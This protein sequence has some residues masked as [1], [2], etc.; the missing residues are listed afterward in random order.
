MIVKTQPMGGAEP[1][2]CIQNVA[3]RI[4]ALGGSAVFG[5][6][7][8]DCGFYV[9]KMAHVVWR[10]PEGELFDVTPY[11]T[12]VGEIDADG[13]YPV[14][15]EFKDIEFEPDSEMSFTGHEDTPTPIY[16]AKSDNWNLKKAL[17][18]HRT[19]DKKLWKQ[20]LGGAQYHARKANEFLKRSGIRGGWDVPVS[21][22]NV[23][24]LKMGL[25]KGGAA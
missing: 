19:V 7:V 24:Y 4:K 22:G 8:Q 5:W 20:D 3:K 25:A 16:V 21:L 1:L 15:A 13:N 12:E 18:H 2:S 6:E 23:D 10:S 9:S 11:A 17:E 14:I